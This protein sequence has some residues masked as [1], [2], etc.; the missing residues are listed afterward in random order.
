MIVVEMVGK[1]WGGREGYVVGEVGVVGDDEE[2]KGG[3]WEVG[4]GEKEG[5]D[6]VRGK[7]EGVVGVLR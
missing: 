4:G 7:M 2:G 6:Y 5:G 1:R 3:E